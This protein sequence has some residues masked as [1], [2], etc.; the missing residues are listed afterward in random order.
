MT[1]NDIVRTCSLFLFDLDGTLY[2]GD[3]LFPFTAELLRELKKH[4]KEYRFIT[5]NS[6]KNPQDYVEKMARLGLSTQPEEFITSGLVTAH[7][8]KDHFPEKRLYVCGTA[9]LKAEFAA[10][11]LRLTDSPEETDAIVL[12]CDTELNFKKIDDICRVLCTREVPYLATHPDE[13]C[14]T[15]YGKMPD[16]GALAR[17]LYT[18]TG[19]MPQIIGKPEP[20]MAQLAMKLVGTPKEKTAVIG[21]RVETDIES[22]I[23][24]GTYTIFVE[25]GAETDAAQKQFGAQADVVLPDA[26]KMIDALQAL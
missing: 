6:S 2:L 19:K 9:S 3:E 25:S 12:G 21:D 14:P 16:C 5:N 11:G 17:F 8:I 26:G 13:S 22:G 18:A 20:L 15:E 4:G 23:S 24:A 10:E 1:V 7:F